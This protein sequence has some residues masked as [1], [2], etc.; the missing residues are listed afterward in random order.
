MKKGDR[1]FFL[2]HLFAY[3]LWLEIQ[4]EIETVVLFGHWCMQQGLRVRS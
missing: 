1:G 2:L 4:I 3:G